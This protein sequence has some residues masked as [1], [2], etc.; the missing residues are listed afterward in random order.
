MSQ[1]P[2]LHSD[3]RSRELEELAAGAP[4]DVLV[5]GGGVTGAG[6]ALD[7]ASRG[8]SVALIERRDLAHGTSRWSSKLAHGGLRYLAT[9]DVGLAWEAARERAILADRTAPHLVRALPMLMPLNDDVSRARGRTIEVG[10]RMG[11]ALRAAA[12][13]RRRRLPAGRRVSAEEAR[14]WAPELR[15]EGLRG[16]ILHWD[17]QLEDDARLVVGLARTAAA[18]GA[19]ILTYVSALS[20]DAGGARARDELTGAELAIAARHVVNATGVWAGGLAPGIEL[21]P[22]RGSHVLVPAERLGDPRASVSVPLPGGGSRFVFALPRPDGLVLCGITD[23]PHDGPVPDEPAVTPA[24]EA[25]ILDTLS[26]A[27]ER[28]LSPGDVV[29]R[30]AG[31][32][33]LL[34]GSAGSTGDLSRRHALI[35]DP[36]TGVLT[37]VGGKLTTYRRMAQDAV[38]RISA[39]PCRTHRLP[40]VGAGP[41]P[42][43]LPPRLARRY[44]AEAAAVAALADGRPELLRPVAAGVP[45]LGVELRF[46]VERELALTLGDALDRR[47]RIGLVPAWR[48]AALEAARKIVP[49]L[50]EAT[51]ASAI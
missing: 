2:D 46:A 1:G 29:G 41:A 23:E 7:A 47:S 11:D 26:R 14:R 18:H 45:L 43:D 13:T 20:L 39:S 48:E 12:G 36:N 30:F 10:I 6:V 28:P 38:D 25:L 27:V 50:L 42:T 51:P 24:E 44:G 31:L 33:P 19:R 49:E 35:T 8:L 22:S 4:L 34:A 16:A 3:R 37:V 15:A 5:V 9:G 21:R 40:L 17:G 32:R